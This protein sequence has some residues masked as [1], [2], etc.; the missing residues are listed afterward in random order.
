MLIDGA[1]DGSVAYVDLPAACYTENGSFSLA[2]KVTGE[3]VTATVLVVDGFVRL[4]STDNVIDPNEKICSLDE[5]LAMIDELESTTTEAKETLSEINEAL[6]GIEEAVQN[7]SAAVES[8]EQAVDNANNAVSAVE[9]MTVSAVTGTAADA[10]ISTVNGKKHIAFTLPKG[11]TGA[12]GQRG[13]A[14]IKVTTSPANYTTTTGGKTPIKRM[15]LSTIKTQGNVDVVQVG[16]QISYSYYQY[17]V[18]YVDATYAYMDY[19][20]NFR[21]EKGESGEDGKDGNDGANGVSATHS[22]NGTTPEIEGEMVRLT[23]QTASPTPR[24][25]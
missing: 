24:P 1:V 20:T 12:T 16:D 22:W 8:A 15:A 13:H 19:V 2:V 3:G 5:L 17:H 9:G 11:D 18:Y 10:E 4:T 23:A 25:R 21:G 14:I 7:A 6:S